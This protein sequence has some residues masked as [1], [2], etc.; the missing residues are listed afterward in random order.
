RP[1]AQDFP[2]AQKNIL[3]GVEEEWLNA[4]GTQLIVP[5]VGTDHRLAGLF[6]LG[7]KKSEVP[8]TANDRSLLESLAGQVALVYENAQLKERVDRERKIK[9]EVLGR[10]EEQHINLMKECTR[11]GACFDSSAR[12]CNKDGS[13]LTFSMPVERSV[14][15]RYRLERLVGKGGMAAVYEATDCR[16]NRRVAIKIL[17]SKMFGNRDALRRFEREAQTSARLSHPNIVSV[18]D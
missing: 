2:L 5:L 10:F 15:A 4:L 8:Y 14:E 1:V 18:H 13:E 6:L 9:H 3:P 12:T 16:L 17:S 7:E 11:C